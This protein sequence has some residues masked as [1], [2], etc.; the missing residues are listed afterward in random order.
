V[1]N[2]QNSACTEE[3]LDTISWLEKEEWIV[4]ICCNVRFAHRS[5]LTNRDNDK[6]II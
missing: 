2:Q 4:D 6:C 1:K 3:D 5:V